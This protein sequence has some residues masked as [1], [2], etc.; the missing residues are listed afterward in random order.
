MKH[1]SKFDQKRGELKEKLFICYSPDLNKY[2]KRHHTI[3][4]GVK[5]INGTS[6]STFWVYVK[7]DELKAALAAF[8]KD[9]VQKRH[10]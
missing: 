8:D 5:G 1:E 3:P 10:K 6:G 4:Y 2:L 7:D 9:E